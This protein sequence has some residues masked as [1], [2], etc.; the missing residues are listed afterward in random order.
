MNSKQK[1]HQLHLAEWAERFAD[2]NKSG[3]T[4]KQWCEEN[5]YSIHTYNYWKHLLKE[6]AVAQVLPDIVPIPVSG[7]QTENLT[8]LSNELP[9]L[10]TNCTIRAN[11]AIATLKMG[12][13]SLEIDSSIPEDFLLMLI[14]AVRH[15]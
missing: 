13:I 2:Q 7:Q 14:K 12:D 15:A 1:L 11:R 4:V 6:K 8:I 10:N 3:L 5:N 9:S